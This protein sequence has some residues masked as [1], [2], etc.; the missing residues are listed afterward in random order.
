MGTPHHQAQGPL[1][2]AVILG[3]NSKKKMFTAIGIPIFSFV[4]VTLSAS[5]P[6]EIQ[7]LTKMEAHAF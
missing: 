4:H 2:M 3:A 7:D 1:F 5:A 6:T